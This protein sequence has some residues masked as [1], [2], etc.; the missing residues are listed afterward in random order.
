LRFVDQGEKINMPSFYTRTG[1]GGKTGLLGKG[2]VAKDDVR[3]EAIGT[4]DELSSVLGLARSSSSL[5]EV[6]QMVMAVQRDLS[7]MMAELAAD[8]ETIARFHAIDSG[9]V[10]WLEAQISSLEQSVNVPSYFI[11]PGDS[12]AAAA[13]DLARTVTR[14]AERR[15]VSL[16]ESSP[17]AL[18][19]IL[20][21]LN[22]LSSL[23]FI[24]ELYELKQSGVLPAPAK[25]K[26]PL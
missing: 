4:V 14:R 11:L 13:L 5:A 15:V 7:A 25:E 16:I 19:L 8:A 9:R 10:D 22:R 26:H 12:Q 18:D 23:F 3:I 1:D 6:K 24:L 2:R 21:Y 17:L 20:K